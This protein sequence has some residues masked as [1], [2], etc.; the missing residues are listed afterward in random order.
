VLE[1]EPPQLAAHGD[2]AI[3]PPGSWHLAG[4]V[5]KSATEEGISSDSLRRAR[6]DLGITGRRGTCR[7]AMS[8]RAHR[9][10]GGSQ[11]TTSTPKWQA[12]PPLDGTSP[13][14]GAK[15]PSNERFGLTSGF[16]LDGTPDTQ[17]AI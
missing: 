3:P 11:A 14:S 1:Q 8:G 16:P 13:N 5:I 15:V 10:S 7:S 4:P 6:E 2:L 12:Q 9:G 17:S